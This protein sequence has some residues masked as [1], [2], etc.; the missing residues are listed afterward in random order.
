M[1]GLI[2]D[3]RRAADVDQK[4]GAGG[5]ALIKRQAADEIERFQKALAVAEGYLLNA[6]IDLQTGAPKKTAIQTIDGG[7]KMVRAA[8]AKSSPSSA[9]ESRE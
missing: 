3:L 5:G 7:L 9:P 6:L 1:R 8:L 2:E 4:Y